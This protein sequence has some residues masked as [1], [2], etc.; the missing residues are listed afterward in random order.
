MHE[1]LFPLIILQFPFPFLNFSHLSHSYHNC[2]SYF[3][4]VVKYSGFSVSCNCTA[5]YFG[6]NAS[7][8]IRGIICRKI[9]ASSGH[10]IE[11]NYIV[12]TRLLPWLYTY[13]YHF[14]RFTGALCHASNIYYALY[15]EREEGNRMARGREGYGE[16]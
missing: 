2:K 8:V 3:Y 6:A 13:Y 1:F 11:H 4:K 7:S 12:I 9:K 16:G 14:C 10:T 15:Q 5:I